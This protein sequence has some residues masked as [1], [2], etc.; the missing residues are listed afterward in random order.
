MSVRQ[1]ATTETEQTTMATTRINPENTIN[2][3]FASHEWPCGTAVA[4]M[5]CRMYTDGRE[6][7]YYVVVETENGETAA[8]CDDETA[9]VRLWAVCAD[10]GPRAAVAIVAAYAAG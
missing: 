2:T 8:W 1:P 4:H 7:A 6:S 10:T 5:V 9:A 3:A